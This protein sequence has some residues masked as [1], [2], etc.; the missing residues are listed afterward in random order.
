MWQ[1]SLS[2]ENQITI[3]TETDLRL[4][5][6]Q[7]Q[8]DTH[9]QIDKLLEKLLSYL[10]I[11]LSNSKNQLST[12]QLTDLIQKLLNEESCANTAQKFPENLQKLLAGKSSQNPT[13]IKAIPSPL[14]IELKKPI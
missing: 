5:L 9:L 1:L 4:V 10:S 6:D 12:Q 13:L 11:L 2:T 7:S 3:I 14:W 8:A